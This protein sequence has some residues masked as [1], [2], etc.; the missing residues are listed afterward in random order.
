[1]RVPIR[2]VC[3]FFLM[4]VVAVP[5]YAQAS[6]AR[7]VHDPVSFVN[8]GQPLTINAYLENAQD[9]GEVEEAQLW[10]KG[11]NE[12][13][14][15]YVDM[16]RS[17]DGWSG[18]IQ[19][20]DIPSTGLDYY[21]EITFS[22]GST[23][24]YP[25]ANPQQNPVQVSVRSAAA[26]AGASSLVVISPS[27]F[28]TV[29]GDVLIA[30][31][32]NQS[33]RLIDPQKVRLVING[34]N[35]TSQ[36]QVSDEILIGVVPGI[37]TGRVRVDVNY[38]GDKGTENLGNFVFTHTKA[39]A[40]K[41]PR[42]EFSGNLATEERSQKVN[43]IERRIGRQMVNLNYQ[44]GSFSVITN[45]MLTSEE[46]ASLQPQH[47]Y[48][49]DMGTKGL[50]IRGGD[51]KPRYNEL[52]LWGK[53]V[54]G[55]EMAINTR[56]IGLNFLYGFTKRGI[57]GRELFTTTTDT[58]TG[59]A[60]QDTVLNPGVYQRWLAA[61]R[62][63]FGNKDKFSLG[64]MAMKAKD[65]TSSIVYGDNAIDNVVAGVD[66][67]A[68]LDHRR[69]AL[70]AQA[71]LS[72]TSDDIRVAPFDDAKDFADIIVINSYLDPLPDAGLPDTTGGSV[73]FMEV[74]KSILNQAGSYKTRLRLRYLHNDLQVG[75]RK[76]NRSY[77]TLG[78]PTLTNDRQGY[79]VRDRIRLFQSSLYLNAGYDHFFDNVTGKGDVRNQYDQMS[80]GINIYTA[81]YLP[82]LTFSYND[83]F[84]TNDGT[85]NV[86][87]T[88][89]GDTTI[90]D[91]RNQNRTGTWSFSV[92]QQF[93]SG[94]A[95]NN[96]TLII[97]QSNRTDAYN[98]Y[99]TAETKL[100][101]AALRSLFEMPLITTASFSYQK[102]TSIGDLT[103][104]TY[105]MVN[106]RADILLFNR[107]L[108]PYFGPRIT[109]GSGNNA[110]SYLDP[111]SSLNPDDFSTPEEYQTA[112]DAAHA[113]ST[114][115]MVVDFRR[116]DWLGG[117]RWDIFSNQTLEGMFSISTYL[118]N[119][120]F[121][122]WN[123]ESF[124]V[125]DETI[126]NGGYTLQQVTPLDRNDVIAS[127]QYQIRF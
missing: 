112:V 122:Y 37:K 57:D 41:G 66:L 71:A 29:E 22:D 10:H 20:S 46:Q 82:D 80:A 50:R 103:N 85:L 86:Y 74:G 126:Q 116:I 45:A 72:I 87:E 63:R 119:S 84:N 104:L 64:F 40:K 12:D 77:R 25:A 8:I 70:T 47:R 110:I 94:F 93:G 38:L 89:P 91:T 61:A 121:E 75:Y 107:K 106:L 78:V 114:K 60:V 83:F 53:R 108:V 123:G 42:Q 127:I 76:I 32:F 90:T 36:V 95:D 7:I 23:L 59:E 98:P 55:M 88:A 3:T 27:P 79:F 5:L 1:M 17:G 9:R 115:N 105:Q 31:A 65:D 99:G 109:I 4:A 43:A 100:M 102:S 54:R 101:N 15:D 14:F 28:S 67:A 11:H 124:S 48:T 44:I 111:A 117:F 97:Q 56:P 6:L 39:G 24:N 52:V 73:D 58:S 16:I 21:I 96:L 120:K 2:L 49:V 118:E 13:V 30:V 113:Q 19:P 125:S 33:I 51:I 35:R 62:L 69:I 92:N 81:P 18:T 34:R 26:E 68:Y